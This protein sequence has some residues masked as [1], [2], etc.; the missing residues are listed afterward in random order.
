MAAPLSRL[1]NSRSLAA[2]RFGAVGASGI[3]VNQLAFATLTEIG[4][5]YYLAAAIAATQASSTWNFIG[6]EFWAFGPRRN[7]AAGTML[8]RLLSFL[9]INNAALFLRVPLLWLLVS[10][11]GIHHLIANLLTLGILFMVRFAVADGWIWRVTS[12]VEPMV[13]PEGGTYPVPRLVPI[14]PGQPDQFRYDIAGLLRVESDVE[15]PEL[16]YFATSAKE[17]PDIR[18]RTTRVG[19]LP[20]RQSRFT[21]AGS[22]LSYLEQLGSASANFRI[23]M[24]SPIEVE[25]SPL[26]AKS[27]HVLYTNVLEALLRFLLVS[28]GYVLLHSAAMMVDGKAVLLSAQTDTGKTSTVIKLVRERGYDFLSDDMTI[29]APDGRA[30]CY[31]KPMT[32]SSHTMA[33]ISGHELKKRQRVALAI[34]SRL[35]SK[36]GRSVGRFLGGLQIPI[37]SVNSVVQILVPPPKYRIDALLECRIGREAQIGHVVLMERGE[38]LR[39]RLHSHEAIDQLVENTDDAYGFPPFATFAPHITIGGDDY[40]TLRR[41]ERMLLADAL[42]TATVWRLRV[43]GHEWGE[44]LPDLFA[45]ARKVEE[46]TLVPLPVNPSHADRFGSTKWGDSH[47]TTG[48]HV[49]KAA[50]SRAEPEARVDPA[51]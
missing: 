40:E 45:E 19:G 12:A 29:V 21:H 16:G 9:A 35:H 34:Q 3:V 47:T 27:R 46:P 31:P 43:P 30:I 6:T 42:R 24:G 2:L 25:V 49:P 17:D 1:A 8:S 51:S 48:G 22:R 39:E 38:S 28:R 7:R 36:S 14:E 32:L 33:V 50:R 10:G 18:I 4:S 5:V 41:K 15:L 20:S 44:V 11:I 26:L 13:P 37:M 23:V